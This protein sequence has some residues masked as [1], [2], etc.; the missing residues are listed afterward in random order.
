VLTIA[1]VA[2]AKDIQPQKIDVRIER[3]TVEGRAWE[4]SFLVRVDLGGGL[5]RREQA[6]LFNSARRCE[7]Y[8]LLT[9]TLRFDYDLVA[10]S[11]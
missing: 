7:V 4:T 8:K 9:G 3:Q 1:A 6:I 10:T 2:E 11:E 5:D